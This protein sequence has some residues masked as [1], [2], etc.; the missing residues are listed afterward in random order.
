VAR[1]YFTVRKMRPAHSESWD[2]KMIERLRSQ[3]YAP[4]N[5]YPVAFF[6]ALPDEASCAAARARLE[7]EGFS[8]DVRPMKVELFGESATE[9][10]LPLSLHATKSMRL[11]L[12]DMVEHSH[13]F[14]ALAHELNGRYD[15]WAA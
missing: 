14:T 6:L 15:G 7:P 5:D 10:S 9:G 8:V 13:R 12:L 3:G 2:E 4:F 1:L 11:I